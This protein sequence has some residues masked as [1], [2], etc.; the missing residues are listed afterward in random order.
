[1]DLAQLKAAT[2]ELIVEERINLF[3]FTEEIL[4]QSENYELSDA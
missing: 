2:L 3:N 4:L 1:M